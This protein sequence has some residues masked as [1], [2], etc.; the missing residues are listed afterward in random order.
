MIPIL[1]EK[2]ETLF[3]SNGLGRL[4]DVIEARV[5]EERNGIYEL[6]FTYPLNGQNYEK[7]QLGRIVAVEHDDSGDVQPFDIVSYSRPIDGVVTFHCVHVSYRQSHMTVTGSNI[8]SLADAFTAL[9]TASPSNPFT[10]WTDKSSTGYVG[11]F[12][13]VPKS[14][15]SMLGGVEGSIL[16]AYGG[17]YE[18]DKFTVKLWAN[19]GQYRDFAIRYGVNMMEYQDET[20]ASPCYSSIIP[21]WTDGTTTIVGDKQ[22]LSTLPPSGRDACVPMDVSEKFESQP[23][24]AQVNSMGLSVL[25]QGSPYLP[26]QNIT[27]S[28]VRL[29]DTLEY[30]QFSSLLRCGLCDTINVIFPDYNSSGNFKIVKTVWDVL[31]ERYEEMELGD[32]STSLSE[33]LGISDI[34]K[35]SKSTIE[36]IQ[37]RLDEIPHIAYGNE[38]VGTVSASSYKDVT[39]THNLGASAHVVATLYSSGTAVNIGNTT[40]SIAS[41]T[42]TQATIRIFNNRTST[43][44]P[45]LEWI[46]MAL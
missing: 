28:F 8:N 40:V 17:E 21:Y 19:R 41:I 33:A 13:G 9:G 2:D 37:D 29:Q 30:A 25:N 15:R 26:T 44:N 45:G 32:L 31:A 20:D 38:S 46:A 22:T 14:V 4:R 24:K 36:Q 6:D 42:S 16:D 18:W 39:I 43:I 3:A 11:A 34:Q 23:T 35:D 10:Y 12:D 5:T 1:Y 7:I 27:V